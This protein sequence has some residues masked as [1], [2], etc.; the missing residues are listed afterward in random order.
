MR[1]AWGRVRCPSC[2]DW[3]LD[4]HT[5]FKE[6]LMKL[7]AVVV[8]RWGKLVDNV[9]IYS[10]IIGHRCP[11]IQVSMGVCVLKHVF[12]FCSPK[13]GRLC[14][15]LASSNTRFRSTQFCVQKNAV[16][17]ARTDLL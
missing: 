16:R 7:N 12:V 4:P 5:S 6:K 11:M 9:R 2:R 3:I 1:D 8:H 17:L 10:S 14:P 13:S 15:A